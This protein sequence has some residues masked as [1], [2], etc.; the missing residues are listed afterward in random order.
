[1]ERVIKRTVTMFLMAVVL[2]AVLLMPG[3]KTVHAAKMKLNQTKVY[4]AKGDKVRLKVS[5]VKAG[6]VIWTSSN[7]KVASVTKRGLVTAKKRG[8]AV[9]TAKIGKKRLKCRVTVEK[10]S[11]NRARRLRDY[12]LKYGKAEKKGGIIYI[13]KKSGS[14]GW[15]VGASKKNKTLY[16]MAILGKQKQV[17]M[18]IN[19]I[20]GKS[21]VKKGKVTYHSW[22]EDKHY[23]YTYKGHIDTEDDDQMEYF[24]RIYEYSELEND[25]Q[26]GEEANYVRRTYDADPILY[27]DECETLSFAVRDAFDVWDAG[28][29]K[30]KGLKKYGISMK[31]IGFA[32]R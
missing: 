7:K 1:M 29:R 30:R 20:S 18:T 25:A 22:N 4:M 10:K 15:S 17:D 14:K 31:A 21:A 8:K 32:W 11:V 3:S 5:G 26:E 23:D 2:F 9:V 12:V 19:L 16:F 6:K 13:K 27:N 24:A 28:F